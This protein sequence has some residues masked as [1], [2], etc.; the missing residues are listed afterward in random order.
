MPASSHILPKK[1]FDAAAVTKHTSTREQKCLCIITLQIFFSDFT[2][3]LYRDDNNRL[4]NR[5]PDL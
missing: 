5:F 1:S 3:A 4:R 2:K